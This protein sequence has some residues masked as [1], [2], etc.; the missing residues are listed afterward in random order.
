MVKEK[1]EG[2]SENRDYHDR[3][4]ISMKK[5]KPKLAGKK[6][7]SRPVKA[8][9]WFEEVVKEESGLIEQAPLIRLGRFALEYTGYERRGGVVTLYSKIKKGKRLKILV[10]NLLKDSANFSM[11]DC[12][13]YVY[14]NLYVSFGRSKGFRI[15]VRLVVNMT[16][17]E[18]N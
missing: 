2:S 13:L 10:F 6:K 5:S 7:A 16:P 14:D 18:T 9:V 15:K 17:I 11:D 3:K 8:K 4:V 12:G 1:R